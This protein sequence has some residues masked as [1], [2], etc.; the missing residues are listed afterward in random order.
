VAGLNVGPD[1]T[2]ERRVKARAAELAKG[3]GFK[4]GEAFRRLIARR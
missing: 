2:I 3:Y 1:E 4:Y